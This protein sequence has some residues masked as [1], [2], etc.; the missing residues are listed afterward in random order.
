MVSCNESSGM[1]V[2]EINKSKAGEGRVKLLWAIVQG[3]VTGCTLN[4]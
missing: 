4:N 2:D 3:R 1:C